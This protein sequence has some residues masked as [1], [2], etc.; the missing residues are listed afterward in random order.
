[1]TGDVEE[2][3]LEMYISGISVRKITGVTDA[4]S[5]ARVR[6]MALLVCVGV[7]EAGSREVFTRWGWSFV[8]FLQTLP[9]GPSV[10]YK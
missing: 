5:K 8:G 6:S 1:M 7:D 3:I 2:A 4:P 9:L 10:L